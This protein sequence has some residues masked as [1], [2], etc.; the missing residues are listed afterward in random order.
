MLVQFVWSNASSLLN[1]SPSQVPRLVLPDE[2]F[3]SIGRS[4]GGEVNRGLQ[5]LQDVACGGN[6]K[7]FIVV[8]S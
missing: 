4:L 8:G 3:V 7:Q 2:L 1:R 5:F 6:L